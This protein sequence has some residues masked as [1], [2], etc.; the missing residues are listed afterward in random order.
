MAM[1]DGD[2]L[3]SAYLERRPQC[4]ALN[5]RARA[6]LGGGVG[7]DLRHFQPTP[8]YIARARGARKW[9]VDGNEYID[10]QCGNGAIIL[11]HGDEEVADAVARAMR[12][13]SHFGSDH[14][15]QIEWAETI[16]RM[17]PSA[18][19]VRFV[20]S[21][22]EASALAIR[23]ARAFT[24]RKKILRFE[25][26]FHGW[27]DDVVHGFMPPFDADGSLGVPPRVREG[28]V[29][30]KDTDVAG[31]AEL[32]ASDRD[33]AAAILE[34]SGASWGRVPID[35]DFLKRLRELS[36]RH[37]VL[38]IF[39]EVV[40]GFRW[41][42]GGAQEV[43]GVRPDLTC[44]AK[45]LAGG[46]PGGAVAGRADVFRLFD[47]TGDPREDRFGRVTHLGT[48]NASPPAAAAGLCVLRRLADGKALAR[49]NATAEGLRTRW[50]AVLERE[51]VAGYAYG[52]ASTFHVFF[53]TDPRRLEAARTSADLHTSDAVILKGMPGALIASFQRHL[54]HRGVDALS[55]TGGLV[56]AAHTSD[57]IARATEVF[58]ETVLELL[59]EGHIRRLPR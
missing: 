11:G 10:F 58:R 51:G 38:L 44:L 32:L 43:L 41:S 53:E 2:A 25:G 9:D 21:G 13:G 26:H 17:V 50:N 39:D 34:P 18:E 54:R 14:P 49:A 4:L 7:H 6:V 36:E 8:L 40:T 30:R 37:G 59:R 52:P 46:M 45:I 47:R 29:F 3:S 35:L 19:R 33:V 55:S 5:R 56:S 23:L 28:L 1:S 31:V 12:L 15:L 22:S 42:P 48:F 57:D 27:L 16:G 24:G 20:N